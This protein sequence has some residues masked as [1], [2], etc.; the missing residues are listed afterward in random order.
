MLAHVRPS[1]VVAFMALA[2]GSIELRG[3]AA[4]L[5]TFKEFYVAQ[6]GDDANP[7]SLEKP[8][9]TLTH[10]AQ[11][12][13]AGERVTVKAGTYL[14]QTIVPKNSGEPGKSIVYRAEPGT[15]VT[16]DGARK[17]DDNTREC[18]S[19]AG[20]P[21]QFIRIEGFEIKNYGKP[22]V[23]PKQS[24]PHAQIELS[25]LEIHH[26]ERGLLVYEG[27]HHD[28]LIKDC[29]FHH[30]PETGVVVSGQRIRFER[31]VSEDN[32]DRK[33][34]Q[35][36]ADGFHVEEGSEI[37][38]V[39]CLSQ[40]NSEDG[41]DLKASNAKLIRCRSLTNGNN[42]KL[43]GQDV[44]L[45]NCVAYRAKDSNL[46]CAANSGGELFKIT[47]IHCTIAGAPAGADLG[48]Y[49]IGFSSGSHLVVMRNCIIADVGRLFYGWKKDAKIKFDEDY[50]VF[51]TGGKD[52]FIQDGGAKVPAAEFGTTWREKFGAGAHSMLVEDLSKVGFADLK[53]GDL[54]LLINSKAV[55]G[56]PEYAQKE[57]AAKTPR[58]KGLQDCGAYVRLP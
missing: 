36:D 21:F 16:L 25:S 19:I 57:D 50:N 46:T 30:I 56:S 23:F 55:I 1:I 13:N 12:L 41:F 8:W 9:A 4:E 45:I 7:G 5:E 42:Y 3:L 2:L 38:F 53:A 47:L 31:C 27:K 15:K 33:G 28:W 52:I 11:V 37:E 6:N 51:Q 48:G 54:R 40:R 17:G 39:E 49:G 35:G 43:W 18:F 29:R 14:R 20:R 34:Q 58:G 10:A 24:G 44:A 32:D 22:I 26:C